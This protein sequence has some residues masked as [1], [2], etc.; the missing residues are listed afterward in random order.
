M[1]SVLYVSVINS[2]ENTLNLPQKI[3]FYLLILLYRISAGHLKC[4]P[5]YIYAMYL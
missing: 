3:L 2:P 4:Y 1:S 5:R